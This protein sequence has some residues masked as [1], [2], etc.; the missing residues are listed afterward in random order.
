[1]QRV[2]PGQR[3]LQALNPQAILLQVE[4]GDVQQPHL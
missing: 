1:L 3:V 4:V 2:D